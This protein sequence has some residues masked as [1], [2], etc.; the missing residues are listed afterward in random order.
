MALTKWKQLDNVLPN[1][2]FQGSLKVNGS[3]LV[4]GNNIASMGSIFTQTGSYWNTSK[5]VAIN[6]SLELRFTGA[7]DHFCVEVQGV[8]K[9]KINKEGIFQAMSQATV[10]TPV[11]GGLFYSSSNDFFLGFNE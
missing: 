7:S 11:A 5:N 10:P 8:D 3:V 9:I 2:T 4:N 6:G 1:T